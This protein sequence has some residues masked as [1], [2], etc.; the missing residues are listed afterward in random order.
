VGGKT[1][2]W[3]LAQLL[4]HKRLSKYIHDATGIDVALGEINEIPGAWLDAILAIEI[5]VPRKK[6]IIDKN[7]GR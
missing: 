6:A 1:T 4:E 2:D 3:Y 7:K 5:D